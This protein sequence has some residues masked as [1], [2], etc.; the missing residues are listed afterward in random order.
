MYDLNNVIPEKREIK[1]GD[2]VFDVT[3]V[4][5]FVTLKKDENQKLKKEVVNLNEKL[6]QKRMELEEKYNAALEYRLKKDK[7]GMEPPATVE[8][9]EKLR[10]EVNALDKE[11]DEKSTKQ[12]KDL[13]DLTM[14][15]LNDKRNNN[16]KVKKD[17]FEKNLDIR[18]LANFMEYATSIYSLNN[19]REEKKKVES[20]QK[21]KS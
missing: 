20:N 4:P 5:T 15:V 2:L 13:F 18:Q 9:L 8:E 7:E 11:Y 19:D 1:A 3:F 10:D 16:E 6:H 21:E 14:A 17:W 12:W